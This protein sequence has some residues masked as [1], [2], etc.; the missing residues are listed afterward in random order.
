MNEFVKLKYVGG[1]TKIHPLDPKIVIQPNDIIE[2]PV[3]ALSFFDSEKFE[4][5]LDSEKKNPNTKIEIK[6][7]K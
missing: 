3:G 6:K 1:A 4:K 5:V 7:K 2:V